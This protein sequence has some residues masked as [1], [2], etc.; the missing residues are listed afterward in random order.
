MRPRKSSLNCLT[1]TLIAFTF[2]VT[3]VF[4]QV[5]WVEQGPGPMNLG[6]NVVGIPNRPQ[7][8]AISAIAVDQFNSNIVYVATVNGGIWKT[9][10]GTAPTPA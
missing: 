9:T 7:A 1:R 3:S 5:G 6:S 10:N 8:G 4:S 2:T